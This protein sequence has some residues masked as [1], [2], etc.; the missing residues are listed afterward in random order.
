MK[1]KI[2]YYLFYNDIFFDENLCILN[3][4][5]GSEYRSMTSVLLQKKYFNLVVRPP[6]GREIF[7]P[8][9]DRILH[10]ISIQFRI[11]QSI[12]SRVVLTWYVFK[13]NF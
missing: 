10:G 11:Y 2:N 13:N 4:R 9:K 7:T 5:G 6:S 8:E 1:E 12:G 3:A